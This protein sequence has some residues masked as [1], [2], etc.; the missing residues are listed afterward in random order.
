MVAPPLYLSFD[1]RDFS[2]GSR[3]TRGVDDPLLVV[4]PRRHLG[5]PPLE[6][7][8]S[9]SF[10]RA[11]RRSCFPTFR[12]LSGLVVV[13]GVEKN[14]RY[15]VRFIAPGYVPFETVITAPDGLPTTPLAP[16]RIDL[17]RDASFDFDAEETLF[18]GEVVLASGEPPTGATAQLVDLDLDLD[19]TPG[20]AQPPVPVNARGQY[21][22]QA[23]RKA[24]TGPVDIHLFHSGPSPTIV[25]LPVVSLHRTNTVPGT[26]VP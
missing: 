23:P 24:T 3:L 11:D 15:R 16:Q 14:R 12:S 13:S 10:R 7:R 20:G 25:H 4:V 19:P 9:S 2:T 6:E 8:S 5:L 22:I 18:R 21:V 1:V 17:H 26:M